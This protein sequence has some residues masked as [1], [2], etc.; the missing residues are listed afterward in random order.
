MN[1]LQ[2]CQRT[3]QEVG[4]SGTG[5]AS[6]EGQLGVLAKIVDWVR[7]AWIE[8]QQENVYWKF[9]WATYTSP[10]TAGQAIIDLKSGWGLKVR[11]LAGSSLYVVRLLE[12]GSKYWVPSMPWDDFRRL[13]YTAARGLPVYYSQAPDGKMH[14][15]PAPMDGLVAVLEYQKSS[16]DLLTNGDV[17]DCPDEY[18]MAIVWRAVMFACAHDENPSLFQSANVNYR[19]L[20]SKMQITELSDAPAMEP[21]A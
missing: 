2:I 4:Y 16:Q 6:V 12:N 15:F 1:F 14:L 18:H 21:M 3:R 19:N 8:V 11:K 20:V 13:P 9:N 7:S 17:P 5:P 10:L